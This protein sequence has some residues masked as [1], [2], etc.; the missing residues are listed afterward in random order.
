MNSYIGSKIR[1]SHKQIP[2]LKIYTV[3]R[4]SEIAIHTSIQFTWEY[5]P[6]REQ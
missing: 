2:F 6:D 3:Y 5:N 1:Q 4:I